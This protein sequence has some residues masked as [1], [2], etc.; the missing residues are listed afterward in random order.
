MTYTAEFEWSEAAQQAV[1]T[2]NELYSHAQ[3]YLDGQHVANVAYRPYSAVISGLTP[4]KHQLQVKV[5]NTQANEVCG[6]LEVE[7]EK[8]HG[9]FAHLA[10]YDRRRIKSGLLEPVRLIPIQ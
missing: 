10:H 2:L 8:Y 7:Q 3:I 4:G 6:T 9:R 5:Y 1:I